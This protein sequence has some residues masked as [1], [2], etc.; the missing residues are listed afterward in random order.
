MQVRK[1]SVL[2]VTEALL[3][4]AGVEPA[5]SDFWASHPNRSGAAAEAALLRGSKVSGV[6]SARLDQEDPLSPGCLV[7]LR[8]GLGALIYIARWLEEGLGTSSWA[9]PSLPR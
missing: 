2:K 1:D 9:G 7:P 4:G 3:P 5:T 6:P 8:P